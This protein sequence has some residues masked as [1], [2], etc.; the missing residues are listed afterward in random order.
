M[1]QSPVTIS[2][3]AFYCIGIFVVCSA[4]TAVGLFLLYV[5]IKQNAMVPNV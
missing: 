2:L 5:E 4:L 3:L 1:T